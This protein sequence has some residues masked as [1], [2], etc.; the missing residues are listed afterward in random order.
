MN[1][2]WNSEQW[3]VPLNLTL[4]KTYVLGGRP[5]SFSLEANYYV[6]ASE[7]FGQEWFIGFSITPVVE[8]VMAK[9]F[10]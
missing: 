2:D 10:K 1:Y 5:W 4:G 3:S 6:E 9:W 7:V 8:N